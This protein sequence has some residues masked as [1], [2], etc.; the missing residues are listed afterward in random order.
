MLIK[1][2][3]AICST[4]WVRR[5]SPQASRRGR[6][7]WR[8]PAQARRCGGAG[9]PGCDGYDRMSGKATGARGD[10]AELARVIKRLQLRDVLVVTQLDR[11]AQTVVRNTF[12]P[13]CHRV[14]DQLD[15]RGAHSCNEHAD[16]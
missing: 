10:R 2:A 8:W 14:D 1:L 6:W 15:N 7:L 3:G 5:V 12:R 13:L 11:L 16:L 4:S 9:R